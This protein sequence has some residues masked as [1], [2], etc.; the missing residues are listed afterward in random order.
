MALPQADDLVVQLQPFVY[1]KERTECLDKHRPCHDIN[2]AIE[3]LGGRATV[4]EICKESRQP[5]KRV[6]DHIDHYSKHPK[7]PKLRIEKKSS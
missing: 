7:I 1:R 2:R 4:G 3:R 6:Q 5:L